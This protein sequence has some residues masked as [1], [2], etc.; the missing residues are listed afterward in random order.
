M[1]FTPLS[2]WRR[3]RLEGARRQ[4]LRVHLRLEALEDRALP[5]LT[6]PILATTPGGPVVLGS[7]GK[8]TD[9]ATLSGGNNPTGTITFTLYAPHSATV[10]DTEMATV[11]GNGTYDTPNGFTPTAVGTYEWTANYSGDAN[12]NP[13]VTKPPQP[14]GFTVF[15][16][17]LDNS[18]SPLPDG[19]IDP[20]Y[21]LVASADPSNHGPNSYVVLEN[22]YPFQFWIAD[23]ATSKW[24]SSKADQSR[25]DAGGIFDYQTTFDLSGFDPSTAQLTGRFTEDNE[26]VDI[27]ING[28]STGIQNSPAQWAVWTPF[29]ISSGFQPGLNTIVFHTHNDDSGSAGGVRVEMTGT[30]KSLGA[31]PEAVT[32]NTT[33]TI[34]A[35]DSSPVFGEILTYT[36]TISGVPLSAGAPA[37]GTVAFRLDGGAGMNANVSGGKAT[38][39]EKWPSV[40]GHTVDAAFNGDDTAGDF[41]ASMAPELAV[42]VNPDTTTTTLTQNVTNVP[43]A[44][45]TDTYL[46][47]TATFTATVR[48]A[49][50]GTPTG[51]VAFLDGTTT[52]QAGV[53]FSSSGGGSGTAIFT[54]SALSA[55]AHTISAAYTDDTGDNAFQ[56]ST[57]GNLTHTVD[58]PADTTTTITASD[59]SPVFGEIV[60]YTATISAVSP[61]TGAP[62]NGTVTFRFDGGTGI[63]ANVSGGQA[64]LTEKWPTAAAG[65]TVDAA[66]N[67]DDS[68]GDFNASNAT[69]L[70]VTVNPDPTTTTLRQTVTN[71]PKPGGTDTYVNQPAT[72]TAI[73]RSTH[74]NTPTGSVAFL[75]GTTTLQAGVTFSSSGG[76]SATA[77]FATSALSVGRHIISAAYTDDSGDNAF[78]GSIS[79]NLLH[80][81]DFHPVPLTNGVAPTG[82]YRTQ[83]TVV[84]GT[85]FFSANDG[86]HGQEL[87]G[88]NGTAAG[89][90]LV[91]DINPGSGGSYPANLTNVNGTLFFSAN[92][93]SHGPELWRSNGSTAGTVLVSDIDPGS[94]G[95]SP[96][97]LTNINGALFFSATDGV[98]GVEL[99]RSNGT[100]PGTVLVKDLNAGS[101][102]SY[103][104]QLTNLNGTLIFVANDGIHGSELFKSNG[105][106]AGT[107]LVNDIRP[108]SGGSYPSNLTVVSGT[109]FFSATNG[110]SG[111]ELWKSNGMTAG[112]ILVKDI[113]PGSVGSYPS[114][115]TN[116]GGTLFFAADDGAHGPELFESDGVAAG[117]FL[118]KD[119]NL[120][121]NGSAPSNL[122][123]VNGTLFFSANNGVSGQELWRSNGTAPGTVLVE[124]INPGANGSY[125]SQLTNVNGTLFF[126]ANDG[127]H[128]AEL[129]ESNGTG[130]GGGTVLVADINPGSASSSPAS[131]TNVNGTLFFT[132]NDGHH[133]RE[134]WELSI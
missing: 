27:L 36:A 78:Q 84:N 53:T 35:S 70:T 121:T 16:T 25:N 23:T 131:L 113:H 2:R 31:E 111:Q 30:A 114:Q 60:T 106:T 8:L 7:S 91:A 10:V 123:N 102:S 32:A 93:G 128:G 17:G 65:H 74:G 76:G 92:D 134:L 46:H 49:H 79:G 68:T 14:T 80:T 18:G 73:V 116:V 129:F 87:W 50:S 99:W 118:I 55:G 51:T 67:G 11:S 42:I 45:G 108:G 13:V 63:N 115:L 34:T 47:Q 77:I 62:T 82:S 33:M 43:T 21:Q 6:T 85:T 12:N 69:Q 38:I 28:H 105:T 104:S 9:S 83:F 40:G 124:D 103:P 44:G 4:H 41:N 20:H 96:A 59:N 126:V 64:T 109:L 127:V 110:I 120:G 75:D 89:T 72:F 107:V 100:A 22:Q 19:A 90:Q 86:T 125:P 54:T 66:F 57:S 37:T 26:M 58:V 97:N 112:T 88:S 48:S 101:G 52:L 122:T 3:A 24:I 1:R 15:A 130:T 71:V 94:A 39:T 132:A 61:G 95:S 29:T 56:G 98:H 119:I 117:T 5:S 133:G 81:V